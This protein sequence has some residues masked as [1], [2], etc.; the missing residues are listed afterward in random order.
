MNEAG[1]DNVLQAKTRKIFLDGT[2][3][4][5]LIGISDTVVSALNVLMQKN[6]FRVMSDEQFLSI[7]ETASQI[8]VSVRQVY[9]LIHN[10]G[11]PAV[12]V[13]KRKMVVSQSKLMQWLENRQVSCENGFA[14]EPVA[15]E[16]KPWGFINENTA[17]TKRQSG[18]SLTSMQ[19]AKEL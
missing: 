3:K 18:G 9:R 12:R 1:T 4:C 10:D 6:R 16:E 19:A 17:T 15:K 5:S 13:G 8:R 2:M 14:T 7:S 11:L